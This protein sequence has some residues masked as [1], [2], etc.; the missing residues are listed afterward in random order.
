MLVPTWCDDM[1][2]GCLLDYVMNVLPSSDEV[3]LTCYVH[4]W[5]VKACGLMIGLLRMCEVIGLHTY[6]ALVYLDWGCV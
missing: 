3:V 6:I 4:V 2:N 1:H 5:I